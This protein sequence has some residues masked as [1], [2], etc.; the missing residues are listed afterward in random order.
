MGV[1]TRV[2]L[3]PVLAE[4]GCVGS[5]SGSLFPDRELLRALLPQQSS[6]PDAF[7]APRIGIGGL[8]RR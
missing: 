5:E 3:V 8:Q 7:A 4:A 6:S 2:V 1:R